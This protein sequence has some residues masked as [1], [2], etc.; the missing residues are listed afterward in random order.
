MLAAVHWA[1]YA[2]AAPVR[3]VIERF[4]FWEPS[5]LHEGRAPFMRLTGRAFVGAWRA[6]GAEGIM[7]CARTLVF[8]HGNSCNVSDMAGTAAA[9]AMRTASNVVVVEYPGYGI[10]RRRPGG[11][12]VGACVADGLGVVAWLGDMYGVPPARIILV[13]HS[14]GTGIAT[15]VAKNLPAPAA[16]LV[17]IAPY[18]SVISV[19]SHHLA[20]A[21]WPCDVLATYRIIGAVHCPLRIVHGADDRVIPHSHGTGLA[22]RAGVAVMTLDGGHNDS[23]AGS[24]LMAVAACIDDLW[25]F[26]ASQ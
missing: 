8:F 1:I 9:L 21:V 11:S 4:A 24:N 17:L 25:R 2:M 18:L 7:A 22:A 13:G 14:L 5:P 23:F 19:V 26:Q 10:D 3:R 20:R 12:R 16:G 15:R 6:D